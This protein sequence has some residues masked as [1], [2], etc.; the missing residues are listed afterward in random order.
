MALIKTVNNISPK[1]SKS[2]YIADNATILGDVT[3]GEKSSVWFNTVLRGDVNSIYIGKNVNIQD[4]TV[5]HCTYN[6]SKVKLGNNISIGHNAIIHGCTIEDNVLIG[7]GA[8]IM[9]NAVIQ[10]NSIVAAGS[11]VPAGKLI[12]SNSIYKGIPAKRFKSLDKIE[13]EKIIVNSAKNYVMYSSW[14][15]EN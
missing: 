2:V 10:K 5:I 15:K 12:K 4:G 9:D 13:A 7:M 11:V 8:I 3:I 14:Y 6:K 1:I